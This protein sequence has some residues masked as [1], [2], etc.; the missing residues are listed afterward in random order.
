MASGG[1]TPSLEFFKQ[2]KALC[3]EKGAKMHLDGA[4]IFN[5]CV[6]MQCEPAD[7]AFFFDSVSVCFAKGVGKEYN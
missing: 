2:V 4:R 5:A 1:T 7:I 6:A 3:D